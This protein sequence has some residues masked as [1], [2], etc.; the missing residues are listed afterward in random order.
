MIRRALFASLVL[1]AIALPPRRAE[2]PVPGAAPPPRLPLLI[3]FPDCG[4]TVLLP[5]RVNRGEPRLFILDSGANSIALDQGFADSIG[6]RS[7]GSGA[8]TGA[9][10]G[11]VAYRRYP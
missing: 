10:A 5:V 7:T 1:G 8:A 3:P 9:G 11:P 4:S 6:L 2:T